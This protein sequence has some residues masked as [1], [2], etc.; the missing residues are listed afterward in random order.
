MPRNED[1]VVPDLLLD[2]ENARLGTVQT[3]QPATALALAAQQGRRLVNLAADIV[4]AGL[5]PAQP[6]T[7]L[8]T[9]KGDRRRRYTV[10]EGNRRVLAIKALETPSL[11]A[12]A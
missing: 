10:L 5:D 1:I 3:T 9:G 4:E 12:G 11:V 8:A 2:P 6:L 7:V